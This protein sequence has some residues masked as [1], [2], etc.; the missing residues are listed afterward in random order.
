MVLV[1]WIIVRDC[2]LVLIWD[3]I[4][5]YR[6]DVFETLFALDSESKH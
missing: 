4:K 1:L 2:W 3:C 6:V 5:A